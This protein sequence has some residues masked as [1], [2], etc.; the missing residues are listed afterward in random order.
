LT[1]YQWWA[2][3]HPAISNKVL[4]TPPNKFEGAT[5]VSLVIQRSIM[6]LRCGDGEKEK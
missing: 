3:A 2:E 4:S 6:G 5:Q 1:D